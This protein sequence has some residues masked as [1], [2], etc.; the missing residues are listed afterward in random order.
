[1]TMQLNHQNTPLEQTLAALKTMGKKVKKTGSNQ[2]QAQCPAHDDDKPSLSLSE[3]TDGRLLL[4]CK[5]G[6]SYESVL[7]SL[8]LNKKDAYMVNNQETFNGKAI[9]AK[10]PYRDEN[11]KLL[12]NV[13]RTKDKEFPPQT[14]NGKF[15]LNGSRRVLYRL[16]ELLKSSGTI[17]IPEGE[18]D[19]DE[20]RNLELTATTNM[21]GS[22]N[23]R[24]E[25]AE[26][27]RDRNIVVLPDNDEAGRKW[28]NK[29]ELSL[30]NIAAS[31]KVVEFPD[32]PERGDVSDWLN[33]GGTKERLLELV[34]QAGKSSVKLNLKPMSEVKSEKVEWF[35]DNKIP[36]NAF[37]IIS[38]DPGATKSYLTVFMAACITT[39]T[40]WPD[41]SEI[42][43]KKG[44]VVFFSEEDHPANIIRPRLDAH[45]AD[46]NKVYIFEGVQVNK[47]KENV[48]D[49]TQHLSGLEDILEGI[50]DCRMVVL[51]PV[52]AYLG[53]TN[54]NSN[55][56]VRAALTPLAALAARHKVTII[57]I[58]H[59]N[60]RQDLSY[61]YRGLGSTAFVAQ[62]RS[63]WAVI[64]D[65]DDPN[66]ETRIF[67]P[68]KANYCI[69]PTGLKYRIIDGVVTFEPE[70]WLGHI[71]DMAKSKPH[72]Q[73]RVD[74]AAEWLEER[75][76]TSDV[77]SAVIFEE[78]E[79]AGFNKD[80]LY[81]AKEK[82]K[83]KPKKQGFG[84]Q[85]F[86]RMPENE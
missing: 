12:Y 45:K 30:R 33:N 82:L 29:V 11:G 3:G 44:S 37:T 59:H 85:W 48:F 54:A 2:W 84:G 25:Y 39:G 55:A 38:G 63:V 17:F 36:D 41:C 47:T 72:K 6:C 27:L 60:K 61:M 42:P 75:L 46:V 18:K 35:W 86:W 71:D 83:I 13:C 8:G 77:T 16:P 31:V 43:V 73:F 51:D 23:W 24:S 76:G 78:G 28:C 26:S 21:G 80:L 4:D 69:N 9:I 22:G 20:L 64:L 14:P 81:R 65:K 34:R 74:K 7:N 57:G 70:P 52:T 5:A 50:S 10:Y 62:A 53:D 68:V 32:L 56:E 15:G 49:L 66:R 19:V 40:P 1:M 58:N 67:C 79:A